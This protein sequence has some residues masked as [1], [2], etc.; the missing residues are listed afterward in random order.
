MRALIIT[1]LSSFGMHSLIATGE[2]S[3]V[4]EKERI[5]VE[6]GEISKVAD[7][8]DKI[9]QPVRPEPLK[10]I[11]LIYHRPPQ[12]RIIPPLSVI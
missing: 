3:L 2:V 11:S 10:L 5:K 4:E 12:N 9:E 7:I 8:K 6:I 1:F